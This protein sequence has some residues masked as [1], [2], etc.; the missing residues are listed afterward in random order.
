MFQCFTSKSFLFQ[1]SL[2]ISPLSRLKRKQNCTR[3]YSNFI[4]FFVRNPLTPVLKF[5][6]LL[7]TPPDVRM[8]SC[9]PKHLEQLLIHSFLSNKKQRRYSS[10]NKIMHSPKSVSPVHHWINLPVSQVWEPFNK[11]SFDSKWLLNAL[12]PSWCSHFQLIPLHYA[13]LH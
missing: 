12:V 13:W 11:S 5:Q 4:W 8:H 2:I 1:F 10:S 6:T 9:F 7:L 3:L